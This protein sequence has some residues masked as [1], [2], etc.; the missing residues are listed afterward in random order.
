MNKNI[1]APCFDIQNEQNTNGEMC[2]QQLTFYAM[3]QM[4]Q[5]IILVAIGHLSEDAQIK[6]NRDYR[7][8]NGKY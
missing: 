2:L 5:I 1:A 4:L 7:F 3:D 8:P 6:G